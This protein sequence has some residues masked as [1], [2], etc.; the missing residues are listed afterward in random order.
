MKFI[1]NKYSLTILSIIG[2]IAIF[3][4]LMPK[5][6]DMNL[7]KIGNGKKSVV[8]IYDLNLV[9]SNQQTIE[10]NK[11]REI[12]GEQ[13]T[14]LIAQTGNPESETFKKR[15]NARSPEILFFS[16]NGNLIDRQIALIN[17]EELVK[18]LSNE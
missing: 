15:Y 18:K 6:I 11:A 13:V 5:P 16:S 2:F 14:F 7:S 1:K 17:S 12:I 3:L 4:F 8:F 10:I 9:V